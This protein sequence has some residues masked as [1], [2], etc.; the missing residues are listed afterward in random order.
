M[1]ISGVA[2]TKSAPNHDA[3]LK[4]M[5]WLSSDA[6]QKIYAETNHEFPVKPGVAA[7][8]LVTSWGSFTPD[9]VPLAEVAAQ[10]PAALK[11]TEEVNFDG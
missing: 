6:A 9:A 3:A 8:E 5:E 1:N 11:L 10:R 2:M 7:S 4:L